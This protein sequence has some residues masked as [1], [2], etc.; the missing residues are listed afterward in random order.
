VIN[1]TILL[2]KISTFCAKLTKNPLTFQLK[3]TSVFRHVHT[4]KTENQLCQISACNGNRG[5]SMTPFRLVFLFVTT[6]RPKNKGEQKH[7]MT[8]A[9]SILPTI[10]GKDIK[11]FFFKYVSRLTLQ[12]PDIL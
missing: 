5:F 12:S 2:Q 6:N 9:K 8:S 4:T 3:I 1:Q 7:R 10:N 11:S